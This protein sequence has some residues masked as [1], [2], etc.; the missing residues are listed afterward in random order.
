MT[1]VATA[2]GAATI[3]VAATIAERDPVRQ[4]RA[5]RRPRACH[6]SQAPAVF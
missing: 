2:A 1:I 5:G 4:Y 3:A 6:L